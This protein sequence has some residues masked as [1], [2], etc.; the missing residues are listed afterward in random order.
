VSAGIPACLAGPQWLR[1]KL[2]HARLLEY[3]V[4]I[5]AMVKQVY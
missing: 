4:F 3:F 5:S 1:H 2:A